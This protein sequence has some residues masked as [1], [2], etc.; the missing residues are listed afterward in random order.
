MIYTLDAKNKPI[1]RVASEAV[2]FLRGKNSPDFKPN[3]V[4]PVKVKIINLS[5]VKLSDAKLKNESYKRYS[6]YAGGLK[7]TPKKTVFE[8]NPEKVLKES[9]RR[10]LPKNKLRKEALKNL[11][12]EP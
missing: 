9:V 3:V 8:K 4:P 6:G 1:G 7:I 11:I 12:I 5:K 10:M 2:S